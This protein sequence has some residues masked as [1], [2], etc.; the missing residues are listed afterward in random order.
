MAMGDLIAAKQAAPETP[1]IANTGVTADR[2]PEILKV[3]D[4]AIV[5]TG[6]KVDG[7]TWNAVDPERARRLM[8]A[9]RR[10]RASAGA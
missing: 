2:I 6:L 5:G 8:D 4:G 1:I 7:I 10:V 3:A 9:V